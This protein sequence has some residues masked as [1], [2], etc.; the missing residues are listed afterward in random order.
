MIRLRSLVLPA[1]TVIVDERIR[2]G[3]PLSTISCAACQRRADIGV[4]L[5]VERLDGLGQAP[6]A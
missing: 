6:I 5:E 1:V 4:S 3:S 2:C